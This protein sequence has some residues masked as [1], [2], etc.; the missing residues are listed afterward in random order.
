[1]GKFSAPQ[2][3]LMVLCSESKFPGLI[4]EFPGVPSKQVT[5]WASDRLNLRP[6]V[7]FREAA[8]LRQVE[9]FHDHVTLLGCFLSPNYE[10]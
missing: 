3:L 6:Q 8:F 2:Q 5:V 1:M 10:H 9:K 7:S 4:L